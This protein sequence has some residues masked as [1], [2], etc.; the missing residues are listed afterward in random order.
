MQ[1]GPPHAGVSLVKIS[2]GEPHEARAH[3][4]RALQIADTLGRAHMTR[5]ESVCT[6]L[7]P[8]LVVSPHTKSATYFD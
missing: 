6:H 4:S 2:E 5:A 8:I 1:G 7:P 3:L